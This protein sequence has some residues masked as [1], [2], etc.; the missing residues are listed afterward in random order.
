MEALAEE[1]KRGRI[2]SVGVSNYSA[3]QM[4][5]AQGLLTGK[6]TP[7]TQERV[8]GAWKLDPKFSEKGLSKI[9]PLINQLKLYRDV[10]ELLFFQIVPKLNQFLIS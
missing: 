5:Q 7:D 10:W 4:Q 3:T 2:L 8:T 9:E 6:Y 1:V